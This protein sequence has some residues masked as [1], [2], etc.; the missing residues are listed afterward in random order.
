M[1]TL[2]LI[3]GLPGSGKTTL[4]YNM[5]NGRSDIAVVEAD[6]YFIDKNANYIFNSSKLH[7]AHKRCQ[8]DVIIYLMRGFDVIVSNTSTTEKEV[9]IYQDLATEFN[10]KFVSLIVENRHGN[11]NIHN[12]SP[13]KIEQMK[14]RFSIKL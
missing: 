10:A 8:N 3:R 12:V 2:Y 5:C 14:N 7:Q 1:Q 9:K 13:E 4:A 6:H 11:M